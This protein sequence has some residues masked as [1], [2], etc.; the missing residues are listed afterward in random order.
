MLRSPASLQ[1]DLRLGLPAA[2]PKCSRSA[3]YS[4]RKRSQARREQLRLAAVGPELARDRRRARQTSLSIAAIGQ[5]RQPRGAERAAGLAARMRAQRDPEHVDAS[6]CAH[7]SLRAPPPTSD[8]AA[9][10]PGA[11]AGWPSRRRRPKLT[12]SIT[13]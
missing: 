4:A 12:P 1:A 2:T 13:A 11:A 8:S 5:P 7:S 9:T 3:G 6:N 10:G